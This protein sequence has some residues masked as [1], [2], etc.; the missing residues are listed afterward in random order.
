MRKQLLFIITILILLA[1]YFTWQGVRHPREMIWRDTFEGGIHIILQVDSVGDP[2]VDKNNTESIRR[3][4]G[5][6]LKYLGVKEN[7]R[8]VKNIGDRKVLVQLPYI[9]NNQM[10]VDVLCRWPF[11]EFKLMRESD[12]NS[13][14]SLTENIPEG[15][16]L[17]ILEADAEKKQ[18]VV[19]KKASLTGDAIY[20]VNIQNDKNGKPI[21]GIVLNSEGSKKFAK[22]TK[23][24]VGRRLAIIFEGKAISAP[25]IREAITNGQLVI[26]GQFSPDDLKDLELMFRAGAIPAPVKVL[27]V[28]KLNRNIW[29]EWNKPN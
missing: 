25:R 20:S 2:V 15:Y 12:Q 28:K 4:T 13:E 7:D 27:E 8:I 9:K 17:R 19:E 26:S 14:L 18:I 23:D 3:M 21:L 10:L 22:L 11:I 1:G 5:Y 24:N 16:E 6:R 29:Q